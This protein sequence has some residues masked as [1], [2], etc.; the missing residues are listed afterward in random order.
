MGYRCDFYV[1]IS[2]HG[3]FIDKYD[4]SMKKIILNMIYIFICGSFW[5]KVNIYNKEN[6]KVNNNIIKNKQTCQH[7]SS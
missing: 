2:F 3:C 6:N 4:E 7:K 5:K 1:F